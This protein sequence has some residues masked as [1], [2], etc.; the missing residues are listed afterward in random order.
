MDVLAANS[1]IAAP[2]PPATSRAS[3]R[4]VAILLLVVIALIGG[5][6]YTD[7]SR[8]RPAE[9]QRVSA[10]VEL[11]RASRSE[12]MQLPGVGPSRADKILAYRAANGGFQRVE[13]L[14]GVEGIGEITMQRLKPHV[15]VD[16]HVEPNADEPL[17]LSRKPAEPAR[18]SSGTKKPL[19]E[20][21]IDLNVAT[22]AE[23]QR[24]PGIG[25]ALAQR[26]IDE[27]A[28]QPFGRIE[29][30]RRVSGFGVKKI[31]QIKAYVVVNQ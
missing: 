3:Q 18:A 23:L 7:R 22:A 6:W 28:K 17:R 25:P 15:Q 27:R 14:R 2:E 31:E 21:P 13:D 10:P 24:L 1:S 20:T 16:G 9:L 11:N 29:D 26:I 4:A 8:P 5:R 12:L 30:L 19:P